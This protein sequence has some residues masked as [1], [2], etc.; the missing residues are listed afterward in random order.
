MGWWKGKLK[1]L[2]GLDRWNI[3]RIQTTTHL[4]RPVRI[5]TAMICWGIFT[6][7][8]PPLRPQV[9]G[10][11]SFKCPALFPKWGGGVGG[12]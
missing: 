6:Y 10:P 2:V 9:E 1:A 8:R 4:P 12:N 3:L 11:W 5:G 7:L